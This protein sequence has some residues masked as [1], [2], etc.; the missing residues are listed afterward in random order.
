MK[1]PKC[2]MSDL[3]VVY[4][5]KHEDEDDDNDDDNEEE[6]EEKEDF[7]H[8]LQLLGTLCPSSAVNVLN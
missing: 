3:F 8:I 7:G 4:F 6:E 2:L 5:F 1:R